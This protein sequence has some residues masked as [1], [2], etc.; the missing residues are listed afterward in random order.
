MQ[1]QHDPG[2]R[3]SF[4]TWGHLQRTVARSRSAHCT[5]LSTVCIRHVT[6]NNE[7]VTRYDDIPLGFPRIVAYYA[8]KTRI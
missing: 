6:D 3:L 5:V 4:E 8:F 7:Y 2:R 1:I